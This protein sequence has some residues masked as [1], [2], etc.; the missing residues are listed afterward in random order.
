VAVGAGVEVGKT[1]A[2]A[3]AASRKDR[4]QRIEKKTNCESLWKFL[5]ME[6]RS[7]FK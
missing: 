2:L 1:G 3:Q 7:N 4:L 5:E 6:R